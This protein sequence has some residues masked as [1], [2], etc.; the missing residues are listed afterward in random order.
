MGLPLLSGKVGVV[1]FAGLST[2][3][4]QIVGG[5]K[6]FLSLGECEPNLN[7]PGNNNYILFSDVFGN[8]YWGPLTP[9]GSVDGITVESEGTAPTGFGGSITILNF[10]G[11]G[12]DTDQTKQTI[13]GV[14]VGV[15]TVNIQRAV[16]DIQ[17]ANA[18]TPIA[19]VTTFRIGA[20]LTFYS[21][22]SGIV[23]VRGVPDSN[24]NMNDDRGLQNL[25]EIDTLT[26]G[27]GLSIFESPTRTGVISVT[28]NMNSLNITNTGIA[29]L[30]YTN[31]INLVVSGIT[32]ASQFQGNLLGDVTGNVT[33]N[34]SG[35]A[36]GL[37]G[38]PDITVNN[39]NST[40]INTLGQLTALG[41]SISG[42]TTS[43][44][45]ESSSINN[46]GIITSTNGI[47][48]INNSF[49][50]NL[51]SLGISTVTYLQGTNGNFSGL[52]TA[53]QFVGEVQGN[54]IGILTGRANGQL[55][56]EVFSS[57][58]NTLGFARMSTAF[59]SGVGTFNGQI[60]G[61]GGAD[62]SGG[63]TVLS[64][65]SVAD[66]SGDHIL[67]SDG[68]SIVGSSNLIFNDYTLDVNQINSVGF[69]TASNLGV[70]NI[71]TTRNFIAW[72]IGTAYN[73]VDV[74]SNDGSAG[75]IDYYC[76]VSNQHYTRVQAA[77]H[78]LYSG[79]VVATLPVKSGDVIV[80]DTA[81]AID[82]NIHTSGII[83]ATTFS[84]TNLTVNSQS[85][86]SGH[87]LPSVHNS[88][89]I[90]SD[91]VRW[92]NAYVADMHFSNKNADSN[93]VDGTTGDWTLQEG[94]NDIFM[95]N[96][97]TKKKY[98]INL[99]EV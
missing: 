77:P 87:L 96:N 73:R 91:S 99:T 31:A 36:G 65:L 61:N 78:S 76:E 67:Y 62:I 37:T 88:Y 56:G 63:E 10:K 58:I 50:G 43:T 71:A 18:F 85:T 41:F 72:G 32:T 19:G 53:S 33:G 82:Q 42:V 48:T 57:G 64:S 21:P 83:T 79:N 86:F 52:V 92:R 25:T 60:D 55:E 95:I 84:G 93:C 9:A 69:L 16:N 34:V 8:R 24:L 81:G 2:S 22:S 5:E 89:D 26:I 27:A 74:R 90:G 97:I 54:I 29:T 51:R 1:S 45:L 23:S 40:G 66:I 94:E 98:K 15:A 7:L 46:T 11:N 12:V 47:I 13:G 44:Q 30:S 35:T 38:N 6:T 49:M 59:V 17:D 39:I 80:G 20:G 75:R 70:G 68:G 3:R 4:I 14:E 28:G